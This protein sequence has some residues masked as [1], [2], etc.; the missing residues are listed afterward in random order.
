MLRECFEEGRAD[1][2]ARTEPPGRFAAARSI[3]G[4]CLL[5]IL[6]PLAAGATSPPVAVPTWS[7]QV[8]IRETWLEERHAEL[9]AMMRRHQVGMWIIVNEEFHDDPLTEYVAPARPYAGGRDLFVFVDAGPKGLRRVAI[10]GYAEEQLA[11]F[12]ESPADP[13][14]A[15]D[16][17]PGLVAEHQPE[18][19]ALAIGGKRGV[20]RSLGYDTY[21]WLVEILGADVAKR[22]VPA[23]PLIE[24]YLETRIAGELPVYAN[25]VAIT[26]RMVERALSNEVVHPGVTTVGDLRRFLFDALHEARVGAWFQPDI[27]VQRRGRPGDLSRG[28]LAVSPEALVIERGDLLHI[29]FGI[30]ALGLSTDWQKMAY[31]LPDG[32]TEAPSGLLAALANTNR[33]QDA[34]CRLAR[35]GKA[36]G[37][38]YREVMAEMEAASI[39]AQVYSHPLGAQGHGLG[40]SI[41][42]RS[43]QRQDTMSS[44]KTLRPNSWI[45]IEL[46]TKA[47]IPEW[48]GQE[49]FI[50]QE[51]PARLTDEGYRFFRPRQE[52]FYLIH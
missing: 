3:A 32:E 16:V 52:H 22:F 37:E 44:A 50:M 38:V 31:V 42:F 5:L 7:E 18:R 33:L 36:A 48:D 20:T 17:L 51:D 10:A 9:L 15:K 46:N 49:V 24:E 43:A 35:P 4:A 34:L 41:D 14:P 1:K 2:S 8:A 45:A 47:P 19:I 23:E 27:R 39:V 26:E 30:S 13:K 12:F 29:D 28:F 40:A 25:L 21:H 11:R 6:L